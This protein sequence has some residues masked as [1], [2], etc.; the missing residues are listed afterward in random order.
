MD[1]PQAFKHGGAARS[2]GEYGKEGKEDGR[3]GGKKGGR[4]GRRD[5]KRFKERVALR[6]RIQGGEKME[7]GEGGGGKRDSVRIGPF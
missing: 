7:G 4:E 5:T 6:G 2:R 1:E 3:E